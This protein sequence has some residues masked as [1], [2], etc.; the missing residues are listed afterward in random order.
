MACVV[1]AALSVA[2]AQDFTGTYVS[3][4]EQGVITVQLAMQGS[5]VYGYL[6]GPGVYLELEGDLDGGNAVGMATSQGAP[7]LGFFG[8]IEGD[9]LGLWFYEIVNGTVVS[10]SEIEV[11]LT[12]VAGNAPPAAA[13][14]GGSLGLPPSGQP[15]AA[16]PSQA[17]A[18]PAPR[19]QLPGGGAP[20]PVAPAAPT[21]PPAPAAPAAPAGALGAAPTQPDGSPIVATGQFGTLT[22]DN[23]AA[24]IE[25]LEF[26]LA[27]IG[28]A[29][30]FTDAERSQALQAIAQNYPQLTQVEQVTLAQAR[31]IWER[32]KVNWATTSAADQ[33][34]FAVGV[35]VLAF[36]E[37]TVAQWAGSGGAGGGGGSCTTFEDCT[38]SLLDGQSWS[39]T[40]NAQ[41][42]WV[43]AGCTSYDTSGGTFEYEG[44]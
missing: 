3:Q 37:E 32:V 20:A 36:G 13:E 34:E 6:E 39:D 42:C 26:V 38:G 41:S 35:L 24:F 15:G 5:T 17:A 10:E 23:A 28:Y 22:Q 2:T 12:R 25:A 19:K 43:A 30:T 27:Q 14:A 4:V 29:Y 44:Y 7:P 9:T 31:Y 16:P 33:R 18:S 1:T 21:A 11:L 8:A 40:F